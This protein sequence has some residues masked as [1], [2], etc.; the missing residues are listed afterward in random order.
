VGQAF[1][2]AEVGRAFQPAEVG[3]A[4]QPADGDHIG[5]ERRYR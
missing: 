2:P 1:Q 5:D 3:Q 4:F